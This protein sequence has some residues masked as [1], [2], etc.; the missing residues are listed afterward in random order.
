MCVPLL[1]NLFAW[2]RN[3][4]GLKAHT[5]VHL[6]PKVVWLISV[7]TW[8][9]GWQKYLVRACSSSEKSSLVNR[10]FGSRADPF[11]PTITCWFAT[12]KFCRCEANRSKRKTV[13][14]LKWTRRSR[15]Q[16]YDYAKRKDGTC[17][18]ADLQSC[19]KSIWNRNVLNLISKAALVAHCP[20]DSFY[21]P[22]LPPLNF[23]RS[24]KGTI[25]CSSPFLLNA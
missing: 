3:Y 17:L 4:I 12:Y 8:A 22:Q 13:A 24:S 6:S 20:L 18:H 19:C 2:T 11:T 9:S 25:Y 16:L 23:L 7:N 1:Q 14:V 21:G 10:N 15:S 5:V